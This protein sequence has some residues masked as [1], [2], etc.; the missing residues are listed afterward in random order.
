MFKPRI[1]YLL[2]I[3]AFLSHFLSSCGSSKNSTGKKAKTEKASKKESAESAAE[4]ARKE[5]ERAI[6]VKYADILGVSINDIQNTRLYEFIDEWE[7]VPYKY[8][9][10]AK[11]GV[12]CSNF[13]TLIY[14]NVYSKNLT[15]SCANLYEMCKNISQNDLKEGD[16][17]FF[18]IE[19]GK[20]SHVGVYLG[21]K[22]FVHATTKKGVMIN[23]LD[24]SYYKKYYYNGGRFKN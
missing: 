8:G 16:L 24:E 3:C 7:G 4:R 15:G 18:K 6:K 11:S 22:K 20:I 17:V 21:N 12:D 5:A 19:K 9:G 10:R 1:L 13:A 2:F 23:C 14:E